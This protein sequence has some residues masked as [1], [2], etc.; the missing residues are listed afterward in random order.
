LEAHNGVVFLKMG[1]EGHE[2]SALSGAR[3]LSRSN[4]LLQIELHE[5]N[6]NVNAAIGFYQ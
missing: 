6:A 5:K 4:Y 1:V 3:G 2:M